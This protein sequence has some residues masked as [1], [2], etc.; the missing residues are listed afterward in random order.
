MYNEVVLMEFFFDANKMK[1]L[2]IQFFCGL[3][4]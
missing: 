2:K 4:K 1:V 3:N